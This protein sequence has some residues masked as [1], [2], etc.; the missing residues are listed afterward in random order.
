MA[1][2]FRDAI[3]RHTI[4]SRSTVVVKAAEV[5]EHGLGCLNARL[6]AARTSRW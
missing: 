3:R 2:A 1:C 4:A 5:R 6:A